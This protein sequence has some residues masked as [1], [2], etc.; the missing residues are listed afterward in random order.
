MM[1]RNL[2]PLVIVVT[3]I[4]VMA[5]TFTVASGATGTKKWLEAWYGMSNTTYNGQ[6]V[7]AL[8]NPFAADQ[9]TY[10]PLSAVTNLFGKDI[11]WDDATKTVVI[12]DKPGENITDL[13][14]QLVL[15]DAQIA[16]L[17]KDVANLQAK[18]DASKI[19]DIS[20]LEDML[21]NDY[22]DYGDAVFDFTLSGDK[23]KVTV[24]IGINLDDY[25]AEW[26][27]LTSSDK[28]DFLQNVVNAILDENGYKDA[29]I[30]GYIR[31]SSSS[32]SSKL[33]SFYTTSSGTVKKGTSSSSS[34]GS[35]SDLEGQIYDEFV[36]NFDDIGMDVQLEENG[37]TV[38][39]TL[40]VDL[41]AYGSEYYDYL[42]NGDIK[43]LMADIYD[44][45]LEQADYADATVKGYVYDTYD[46]KN[47]ARY[48]S[49]SFLDLS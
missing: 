24:K 23:N 7:T 20:G 28:L 40:M 32:S 10:V 12:T 41:D 45:I 35:I 49:T 5:S 37:N 39:F 43:N 14:T 27:D 46:E 17:Q 44:Y 25:D 31:D 22:T 8:L 13:K 30:T 18:L 6:N 34:G 47:V 16:S 1:R 4:F 3:V 19:K 21:N 42:D 11:Y 36:S 29:N 2:K 26:G 48:T 15:K 9:K 38:I 33:F